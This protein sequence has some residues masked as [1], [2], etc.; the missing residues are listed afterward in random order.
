MKSLRNALR[1][2]DAFSLERPVWGVRELSQYSGLSPSVVQRALTTFR[3][4]GF[5]QQCPHSKRYEPGARFWEYGQIFRSR[6]RLDDIIARE[7][8]ALAD[9]SAAKSPSLLYWIMNRRCA[10]RW[11]RAPAP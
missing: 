7:L 9:V 10:C 6:R 1:I 4:G 11:H 5:L 8:R 3:D 2:L